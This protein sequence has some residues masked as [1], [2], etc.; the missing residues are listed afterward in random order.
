MYALWESICIVCT[1]KSQ[2]STLRVV[3]QVAFIL[4]CIVSFWDKTVLLSQDLSDYARLAPDE[5]QESCLHYVFTCPVLGL[6]FGEPP[7]WEFLWIVRLNSYPLALMV[8]LK[9][10]WIFHFSSEKLIGGYIG[11][12]PKYVCCTLVQTLVLEWRE[13]GPTSLWQLSYG[14]INGA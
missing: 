7:C 2:S 1:Y 4:F 5:F 8:F 13:K 3:S 6:W 10:M 14:C 12:G 9:S 11:G